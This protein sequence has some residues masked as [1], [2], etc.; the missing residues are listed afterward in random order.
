MFSAI[1]IRDMNKDEIKCGDVVLVCTPLPQKNYPFTVSGFNTENDKVYL[2][3]E[4]GDWVFLNDCLAKSDGT[5]QEIAELLL[6]DIDFSETGSEK[7]EKYRQAYA[8]LGEILEDADATNE[9]EPEPEKI[10]FGDTVKC[11]GRYCHVCEV[12]D[13]EL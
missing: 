7:I 6:E 4:D 9:V 3:N 5:R 2:Y 13:C 1:E 8:L 11:K 10:H 12:T